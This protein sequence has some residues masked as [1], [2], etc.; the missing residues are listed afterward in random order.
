MNELGDFL[1]AIADGKKETLKKSPGKAHLKILEHQLHDT[2]P[3][4]TPQKDTVPQQLVEQPM[5]QPSIEVVGEFIIEDG[6]YKHASELN[7]VVVPEIKPAA[8]QVPMQDIDKYLKQNASFQQPNPDK[9]DPNL[10][11]IQ[12]KLKFLEQAIGKI[13]ATGPGSGEVNL[14]YLDDVKRDTI[15][16]GKFLKYS[17]ADKKFIFDAINPYEVTYN[18]TLVTNTSYTITDTDYYIGVNCPTQAT[19]TLPA[20]PSSGRIVIIKDESGKA[21]LIPII[22]AGTVDGDSNGAKIQ[23]SNGGLQLIYHN[24]S[25]RI[26]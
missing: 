20:S 5:E 10:Q 2:N 24:G 3:F 8:Q 11:A 9:V 18:T 4:I 14:R 21:H 7:E 19:I 23:I 15:A 26:V 6:H 25:W 12:N 13:A 17:H 22:V 16:D 1:K